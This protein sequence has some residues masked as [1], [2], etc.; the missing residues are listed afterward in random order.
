M[1]RVKNLCAAVKHLNTCL[2]RIIAK[3]SGM[4]EKNNV[5]VNVIYIRV[6]AK[7]EWIVVTTNADLASQHP[8]MT[9][10]CYGNIMN[11]LRKE[12]SFSKIQLSYSR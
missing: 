4:V 11:I 6:W 3:W 12:I 2:C 8:S 1:Q 5:I 9:H 7:R 10:K